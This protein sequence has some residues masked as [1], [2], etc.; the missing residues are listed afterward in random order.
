MIRE[1]NHRCP[2]PSDQG[3]PGC[4]TCRAVARRFAQ[5]GY[6][7]TLV[8]RSTERLAGLAGDLADT[9]AGIGTIAGQIA[10]GTAF[11]PERIAE[12]Y[13]EVVHSGEPWQPE[14]RYAG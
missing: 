6:R 8:A 3:I 1:V 7:I 11:A 9:G 2:E 4:R 13:W 12:R 5:G 10:A 14:Y